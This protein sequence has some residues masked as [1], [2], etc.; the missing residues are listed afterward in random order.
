MSVSTSSSAGKTS[1]KAAKP[2]ASSSTTARSGNAAAAAKVSVKTSG[3]KDDSTSGSTAARDSVKVDAREQ[4]E[5]KG[6]DGLLSGLSDWGQESNDKALDNK[7][8]GQANPQGEATQPEQA[9]A[10]LELGERELLRNGKR[11][12][13]VTQVQDMLKAQG[14]DLAVDGIFGPETR[15]A[16]EE[17]QR[18]N[19]LT[20]DGI[21]GPQTQ[22]ALN[23]GA[24]RPNAETEQQT[25][26]TTPAQN[27]PTPARPGERGQISLA[28]PELSQAEQFEHYKSLIEANGGQLNEDGATVLGMRGLGVDGARHDGQSN[29]GGY[30]DTFIVLRNGPDGEPTVQTFQGATHANQRSSR[31]S[32]GPDANGNNIRGVAMLAPGNYDVSFATGNY[33]GQ[34]GGAY[35]VKTQDGNGYVPAYRDTNA[36]GRISSTERST[37]EQ[38]GYQASAILFH[39]GKYANPSSIGC[40]TIIPGQH[41][42]FVNAL[43]RNGFSYTLLDANDS[44]N[45][46]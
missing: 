39:N 17:F 22:A 1:A 14:I 28:N 8:G 12:E 33:Q 5:T 29:V 19:N 38:N 3:K 7:N 13:K 26:E 11:G 37:A 9:A 41:N 20:V 27:D 23:G 21:V 46:E 6:V 44:Y 31:S 4:S 34:W 18:R 30:D 24:E 45:P 42:D 36:D 15:R 35:H 40:Q 25:A 10:R 32:F 16:V 2:T 43:G